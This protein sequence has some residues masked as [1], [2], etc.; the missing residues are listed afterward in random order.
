M[1]AKKW[2]IGLLGLVCGILLLCGVLVGG[3]DPYFHYHKPLSWFYYDLR[4]NERDINDGILKHFDYDAVITGT[5]MTENF[6]TSELDEIFGVHSVKTPFS[7]ATWH[8][9]MLNEETAL[10]SQNVRIIVRGLDYGN[11]KSKADA[12]RYAEAAYPTYLYDDNILNDVC[13]ILN[14]DV[15]LRLMRNMLG[16]LHYRHGGIKSFDEYA[17]WNDSYDFGIEAVRESVEK[18]N[19]K[20]DDDVSS[21]D[22]ITQADILENIDQNVIALPN[23]Y[24]ETDFYY[25]ITPYSIFYW[26]GL[27]KEGKIESQIDAE[28]W[29]LE[30]IFA[31]NTAKNIHLFSFNM[32]TELTTNLDN[33]KDAGHY[34]EWVNSQILEWMKNDEYR[35]TEDNYQA[36]LAAERKFYGTY[37]YASLWRDE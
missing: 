3:I 37:D 32:N 15:L 21:V 6:K 7:G 31:K 24:P 27:Q 35:L 18:D 30:R 12:M 8:E 17:N 20:K 19:T 9:I 14:R 34:G 25:F 23:E 26:D 2:S 28:E 33:Y 5:S 36:Y 1:T 22:K 11:I 29:M 10:S 4:S 13:Y 16:N